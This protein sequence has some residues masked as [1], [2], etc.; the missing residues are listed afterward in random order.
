MMNANEIIEEIKRQA[1]EKH[2]SC[3]TWYRAAQEAS[4]IERSEMYMRFSV[5][6]SSD[7]RLLC[8]LLNVITGTQDNMFHHVHLNDDCSEYVVEPWNMEC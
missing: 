7:E 5:E 4:T 2:I 6:S 1:I 3:V 8:N